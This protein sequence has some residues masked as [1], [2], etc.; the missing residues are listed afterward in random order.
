MLAIAEISVIV[1]FVILISLHI[2]IIAKWIPYSI[3]WGSRL[4][5]DKDMYRFETFT[6]LILFI[7][8]WITLQQVKIISPFLSTQFIEISFWIMTVLFALSALGNAISINKV[9]KF[10]F[11]PLA[12]IHSALC[13]IIALH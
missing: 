6:I 10:V 1:M 3:V 11:T 2:A 12:L 5:S 9:E 8:I 7:F 4:K 13:L